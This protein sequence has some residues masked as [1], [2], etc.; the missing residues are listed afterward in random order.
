MR[1]T[2][3]TAAITQ[4]VIDAV[5]PL[6]LAQAHLRVDGD[7]ETDLIAALSGAAID[8]VLQHSGK[9]L[10]PQEVVWHGDFY[11]VMVAGVG[12]VTE[13]TEIKYWNAAGVEVTLPTSAAVLAPG[14]RIMAHPS[15][16]WPETDGRRGAVKMKFMAG[17]ADAATQ[18][19]SLVA[20]AKLMLGH[21]FLNREAVIAGAMSSTLPMGFEALCAPYRDIR[22]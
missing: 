12:P 8:A 20:A 7:E 9:L 5:L 4:D 19:P 1:F 15:A 18:C 22:I 3:S 21:L 10:W 6:A 16:P 11:D 17:Y 14:D 2:L 13:I